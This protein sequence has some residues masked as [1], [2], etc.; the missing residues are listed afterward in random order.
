[1]S[2]PEHAFSNNI[3]MGGNVPSCRGRTVLPSDRSRWQAESSSFSG[4]SSLMSGMV[5]WTRVTRMEWKRISPESPPPWAPPPPLRESKWSWHS[6]WEKAW[7]V[8]RTWAWLQH[9]S[10]W[11]NIKESFFLSLMCSYVCMVKTLA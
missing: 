5:A 9:T 11:G 10:G 1:V 2:L 6:Q 7:R 3:L 8:P 4:T